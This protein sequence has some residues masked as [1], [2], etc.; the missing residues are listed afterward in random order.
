MALK[1]RTTVKK[2]TGDS[3]KNFKF[4]Y[5]LDN[6]ETKTWASRTI[7]LEFKDNGKLKSDNPHLYADLV[8]SKKQYN[9]TKEIASKLK[10]KRFDDIWQEYAEAVAESLLIKSGN[11]YVT[12]KRAT[13]ATTKTFDKKA[14]IIGVKF[15]H[16]AQDTILNRGMKVHQGWK[17]MQHKGVEQSIARPRYTTIRTTPGNLIEDGDMYN[18]IEVNVYR[19]TGNNKKLAVKLD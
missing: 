15:L 18:A 2:I 14:T 19:G 9:F 6:L 4:N 16:I 7:S 10:G 3:K 12:P 1:K 11:E 13:S 8:N 5:S 17:F